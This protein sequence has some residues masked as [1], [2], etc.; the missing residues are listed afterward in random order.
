[1]RDCD[2]RGCA[3]WCRAVMRGR[4][5][6]TG[7]HPIQSLLRRASTTLCTNF[8]LRNDMNCRSLELQN[9]GL[10][11]RARVAERPTSIAKPLRRSAL[12][13]LVAAV[14]VR[15]HDRPAG[16]AARVHRR[17]GRRMRY[18]VESADK[19]FEG[20]Q[21]KNAGNL[22][23]LVIRPQEVVAAVQALGKAYASYYGAVGDF[24]RAIP[25]LPRPRPS[26]RSDRSDH[27]MSPQSRAEL[28]PFTLIPRPVLRLER[29]GGQTSCS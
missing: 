13:G 14:V 2:R 26:R 11:N 29:R 28:T 22:V 15:A 6:E 18:A 5:D 1:M 8:N 3:R 16:A 21:T 25:P 23:L 12:A 10:G 27:R 17:R 4:G 20:Q 9:L 24:K 19:K 7:R